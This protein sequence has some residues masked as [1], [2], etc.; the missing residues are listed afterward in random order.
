MSSKI[1][2]GEDQ[3]LR[4][5]TCSTIKCYL[6]CFSSPSSTLLKHQSAPLS[7]FQMLFQELLNVLAVRLKVLPKVIFKV[8]LVEVLL[9]VFDEGKILTKW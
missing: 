8:S 6:E 1:L 4:K 9:K 7:A 2:G 5:F 3:E